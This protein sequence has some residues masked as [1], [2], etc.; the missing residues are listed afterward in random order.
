[1]LFF[2]LI[3]FHV[4]KKAQNGNRGTI[5]AYSIF[6]QVRVTGLIGAFLIIFLL[7]PVY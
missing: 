2:D 4:S 5:L 3:L 6:R 1:M 7:I